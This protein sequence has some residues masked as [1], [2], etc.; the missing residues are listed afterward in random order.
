MPVL[1]F[2]PC[3][4]LSGIAPCHCPSDIA[5]RHFPRPCHAPQ[6]CTL[7]VRDVLLDGK[8]DKQCARGTARC[9]RA[10]DAPARGTPGNATTVMTQG[11][12]CCWGR[13]DE[14]DDPERVWVPSQ[15]WWV[16]PLGLPC[17][18]GLGCTTL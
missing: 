6:V 15:D 18:A 4:S 14:K 1:G 7:D 8:I 9:T 17:C 16:P 13:L 2:A 5:P 3:H 10:A 11:V 12:W